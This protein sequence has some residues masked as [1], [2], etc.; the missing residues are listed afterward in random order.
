MPETFTQKKRKLALAVRAG[1]LEAI[2]HL[3]RTHPESVK[4]WEPI[5]HACYEGQHEVVK[6]L[7]EHGADPNVLSGSNWAHRP[8]HR[9]VEHKVSMPRH[10]GHARTVE[11]LMDYGA[12]ATLRAS[13]PPMTALALAAISGGDEFVP[14]LRNG[15]P[16]QD[17]FDSAAIGD[18][19]RL[20]TLLNADPRLARAVDE[21]GCT[22]LWYCAASRLNRSGVLECAR[23][24]LDR[25]SE[26]NRRGKE[27]S[28]P[29]YFAVGHAN[30]PALAELLLERGADPHEG[31][32]LLHVH[33]HFEYLTDGIGWLIRHGADPDRCDHHGQTALHKTA[34]FGYLRAARCL[35]ELGADPE[36]KDRDGLRPVDIARRYRKRWV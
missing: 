31:I 24:L 11:L 9:T 14:L 1:D 4:A 12:N 6:L 17:V 25:G 27:G 36:R 26:V 3:C 29:L 33:V 8:L 15:Q 28:P 10:A 20:E 5:M 19:A 21:A 23:L 22:A 35:L 16:H 34:H 7:L 30:H 13:K 32:S 18:A 2:A